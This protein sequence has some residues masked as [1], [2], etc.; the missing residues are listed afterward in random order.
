MPQFA[1]RGDVVP[2]EVARRIHAERDAAL[3][4]LDR[5]REET[6]ELGRTVARQDADRAALSRR[7][8]ELEAEN[9]ALAAERAGLRADL[10]GARDEAQGRSDAEGPRVLALLADLANLR[11]RR[12]L[13]LAAGQRAVQVR[14]LGRLGELRDSLARALATSLDPADPWHAGLLGIRDQADAELRAEGVTLVGEVGEPFDP[15]VHEAITAVAVPG[16]ARGI[17]LRVDAPGLRLED[18]A[19]ARPA[20]VVVSR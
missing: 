1:R 6:L 12:D 16:H 3:A 18:G 10:E 15:R 19:M 8:S 13:D 20:R 17:V 4:K 11:R 14:L 9:A 7:V 2:L 5:A